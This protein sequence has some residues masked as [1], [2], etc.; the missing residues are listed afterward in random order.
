MNIHGNKNRIFNL[1]FAKLLGFYQILD[2]ETVTFLGHHNVHYRIFV[3]L[4]AYE[5]VMSAI[6]CL[7][8]LY[9]C[10]NNI[11][12]SILY[13]GFVVN[14]LYSSYKMYIVLNHS[15][16]IW[17]C[18]S[19]TQFDFTTYG[20]KHRRTLEVWRNRSIKSTYMFAIVSI[21]VLNCFLA[22]PFLFSN[23]FIMMKNH[24]GSTSAYHLNVLNLYL[25]VSD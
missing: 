16:L 5:C 8:G 19:I 3:L 1:E 14:M 7:N 20:L 11:S 4:I 2:T 24:D 17:D 6:L 10:I 15:K 12:E 25:F 13:F 18:L 23:T 22:C 21:I 9:Y